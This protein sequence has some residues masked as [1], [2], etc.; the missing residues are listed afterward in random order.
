VLHDDAHHAGVGEAAPLPGYSA[1]SLAEVEP[2]LR[3]AAE[4]LVGRAVPPPERAALR[5]AMAPLT[6]L[7]AGLPS[8]L[9]ALEGALL[10]LASQRSGLDRPSILRGGGALDGVGLNGLIEASAPGPRLDATLAQLREVGVATVKVKVG[11]VDLDSDIKSL[12]YII[13][14]LPTHRSLRLDVNGRW[15]LAVAPRHLERLAATGLPIEYVEQPV[16]ADCLPELPRCALP[17][18]ADESLALVHMGERLLERGRADVFV[19]KPT[20][21]GL[22]RALDLARLARSAG[23]GVTVTHCH[24]SPVGHGL[25]CDLALGLPDRP[26]DCGLLPTALTEAFGAPLPRHA[27]ETHP[28]RLGLLR[29]GTTP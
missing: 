14:S 11:L 23:L 18:A 9:C 28:P 17:V 20:R 2:A 22:L 5:Q 8:A 16:P 4:H 19:L 15:S 21:L 3:R 27:L 26:L 24:E 7:L 29:A 13:R 25:A 6:P 12:Y 1:E 10:D